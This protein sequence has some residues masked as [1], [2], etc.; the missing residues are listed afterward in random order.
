MDWILKPNRFLKV[1][2]NV[3]FITV[4]VCIY[5][6]ILGRDTQ[7]LTQK[8]KIKAT[9]RTQRNREINTILLHCF[10]ERAWCQTL[11][12]RSLACRQANP[13]G[14]PQLQRISNWFQLTQPSARYRLLGALQWQPS[15]YW[16]LNVTWRSVEETAG[17]VKLLSER[18]NVLVTVTL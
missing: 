9:T 5:A 2:A 16:K 10:V 6:S 8:K 18:N 12:L 11:Q 15:W 7:S 1:R 4:Y 14:G 3:T 13:R 17:V